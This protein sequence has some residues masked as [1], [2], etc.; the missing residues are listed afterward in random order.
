MAHTSGKSSSD[1]GDTRLRLKPFEPKLRLKR[2]RVKS[3]REWTLGF[4]ATA[5]SLLE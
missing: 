4:F 1:A 5:E 3:N 2:G